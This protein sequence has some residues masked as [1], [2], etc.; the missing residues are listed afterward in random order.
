[1]ASMGKIG[2]WKKL[3]KQ[4]L[5]VLYGFLAAICVYIVCTL[6]ELARI[7]ILEKNYMKLVYKAEPKINKAINKIMNPIYNKLQ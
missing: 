7:Y 6:I 3:Y 5:F 1:M 4:P 2:Y